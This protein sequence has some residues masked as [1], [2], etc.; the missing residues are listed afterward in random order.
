MTQS[1]E[2]L[3]GDW[4]ARLAANVRPIAWD[5]FVR[6]LV[7]YVTFLLAAGTALFGFL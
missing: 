1:I 2:K 3:T 6:R 4:E 7:N 5:T